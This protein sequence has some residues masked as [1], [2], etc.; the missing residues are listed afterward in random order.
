MEF[1]GITRHIYACP[2]TFAP[3]YF[4][5]LAGVL[6]RKSCPES[7]EGGKSSRQGLN[8]AGQSLEE[9]C[10]SELE[11]RNVTSLN[12][13]PVCCSH[14]AWSI[15][16]PH[17]HHHPP[18]PQQQSNSGASEANK[19]T[20]SCSF[21]FPQTFSTHSDTSCSLSAPLPLA[22]CRVSL[23]SCHTGPPTL[24]HG[25][26][27]K[28]NAYFVP[29]IVYVYGRLP[30]P[31]KAARWDEAKKKKSLPAR[32]VS[33]VFFLFKCGGTNWITLLTCHIATDGPSK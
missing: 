25:G 3:E 9:P 10:C 26:R 29:K 4:R 13:H 33:I 2:E 21:S 17:H 19:S 1:S 15:P 14:V 27:E 24:T 31:G 5:S 16:P 11:Q 30:F 18:H 7:Q 20:D 8:G 6:V 12:V 28:L 32:G 23:C 22:G